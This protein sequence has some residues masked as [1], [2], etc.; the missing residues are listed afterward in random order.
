MPVLSE[1]NALQ[2]SLAALAAVMGGF[3]L[4][5]VLFGMIPRNSIRRANRESEQIIRAATAEAEATKQRVELKA[6]KKAR[7]RRDAVDREV[8][9]T[10]AET[11][12]NQARLAKRED[13]LDRKLEQVSERERKLDSRDGEVK[14]REAEI[15][16]AA[17]DLETTRAQ[18][19]KRLEEVSGLT[20]E[21]SGGAGIPRGRDHQRG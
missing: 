8:A 5:W 16:A 2:G 17:V 15:E 21:V 7:D 11:R 4:G 18:V 12:Q 10:I 20:E 3:L 14:H 1:I 6:E 9:E 19:R 13:N